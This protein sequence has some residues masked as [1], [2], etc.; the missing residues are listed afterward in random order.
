MED[1]V[2]E[3]L[4][5]HKQLEDCEHLIQELSTEVHYLE[6]IRHDIVDVAIIAQALAI[7]SIAIIG[8]YHWLQI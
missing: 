8:G 5:L 1:P 2:I 6:S 3:N 7:V 4:H